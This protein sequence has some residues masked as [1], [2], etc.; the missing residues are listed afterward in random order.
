M[1]YQLSTSQLI[2]LLSALAV[3]YFYAQFWQEARKNPALAMSL[4]DAATIR[5]LRGEEPVADD[6]EDDDER[7]G[8]RGGG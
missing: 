2:G 6:G 1:P 7:G 4:G 5:E 8:R 3:S